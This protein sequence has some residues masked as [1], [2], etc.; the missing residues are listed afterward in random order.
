VWRACDGR[1][2]WATA[3]TMTAILF[4]WWDKLSVCV[5]EKKEMKRRVETKSGKKS[6][7]EEDRCENNDNLLP[8]KRQ[9]FGSSAAVA[10]RLDGEEGRTWRRR[11][12]VTRTNVPWHRCGCYRER[13]GRASSIEKERERERSG[14][15]KG[16]KRFSHVWVV[17]F[18]PKRSIYIYYIIVLLYFYRCRNAT[19]ATA[20]NI[21]SH[22]LQEKTYFSFGKA[23]SH[24]CSLPLLQFPSK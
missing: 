3:K 17:V 6:T 23:S 20:R 16:A 5:L 4:K 8:V 1:R 18:P 10:R 12:P 22:M 21:F 2:P 11:R 19:V 14:P 15:V 13:T 24:V 7:V 9:L